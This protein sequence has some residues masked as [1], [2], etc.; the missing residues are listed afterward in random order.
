MTQKVSQ[1]VVPLHA[2]LDHLN[3][4]ETISSGL[5]SQHLNVHATDWISSGNTLSPPWC[6]AT[7]AYQQTLTKTDHSGKKCTNTTI[8]PGYRISCKLRGIWQADKPTQLRMG[9][10]NNGEHFFS[11]FGRYGLC[12]R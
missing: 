10:G 4:N 12:P 3:P 1:T 9:E 5:Q 7:T 11:G 2:D 6:E 8:R